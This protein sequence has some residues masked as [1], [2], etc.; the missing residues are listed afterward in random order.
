MADKLS[1]QPPGKTKQ[2]DGLGISR[3]RQRGASQG[4][5]FDDSAELP[6]LED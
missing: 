3:L 1:K 5:A 4:I 6:A 2:R